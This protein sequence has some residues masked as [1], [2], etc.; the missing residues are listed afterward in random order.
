MEAFAGCRRGLLHILK[1]LEEALRILV[2]ANAFGRLILLRPTRD[3]VAFF[4]GPLTWSIS[5]TIC[6]EVRLGTGRVWLPVVYFN[7]NFSFKL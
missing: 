4:A 2:S 6:W 7:A 3:W 1:R 5:E